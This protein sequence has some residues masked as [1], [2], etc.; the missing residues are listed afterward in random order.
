MKN[1]SAKVDAVVEKLSGVKLPASVRARLEVAAEA[2][3]A[4]EESKVD[5]IFMLQYDGADEFAF[6]A[7][8]KAEAD[9][10]AKGWAE[11]NKKD[12]SKVTVVDAPADTPKD[13]IKNDQVVEPS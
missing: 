10:K 7:D 8:D 11:F 13:K 9:A 2:V 5:P 3:S 6:H 1:L 12:A 4:A